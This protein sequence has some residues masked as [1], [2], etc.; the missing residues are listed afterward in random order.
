MLDKKENLRLL[1]KRIS[2]LKLKGNLVIS[3]D[4]DEL[5]VPI[6]LTRA[7]TQKISKPIDKKIFDNIKPCSFEEIS[8]L[9]NLIFGYDFKKYKQIRDKIAKETKWTKGF[10]VLL[11]KLIKKYSVIFISS[12]MKDICEAKLKEIGF[13][14]NNIIADE[15]KIENNKITG[16][17]LIISDELKSY[18]IRKLKKDYKVVG[19]GHGLGD[20]TMLEN[21]DL[22]ISFNSKISNLAKFNIKFP[23]EILEFAKRTEE[24]LSRIEAGKGIKMDF[25]KFI[26]EMEK[27]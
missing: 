11:K 6:H 20:K 17:N 3:F 26:K 13:N 23:E 4:F 21:S 14:S 22:S 12:G 27:W 19:I 9:N 8:Y 10:D 15:F 18:V 5:V 2:D 24:A 16:I 1:N 25:N 7:I